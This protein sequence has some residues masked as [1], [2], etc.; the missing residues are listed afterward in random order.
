MKFP[1]GGLAQPRRE[2]KDDSIVGLEPRI[3]SSSFTFIAWVQMEADAVVSIIEKPLG[4][5]ALKA[6]CIA[7]TKRPNRVVLDHI[8]RRHTVAGQRAE[9]MQAC[10]PHACWQGYG[11]KA[12]A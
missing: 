9:G 7:S 8:L 3:D 5:D 11:F 12:R 4:R 6:T 1:T 10:T 2:A